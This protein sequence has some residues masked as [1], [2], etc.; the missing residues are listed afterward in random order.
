MKDNFWQ[1]NQ[2]KEKSWPTFDEAVMDFL[3]ALAAAIRCDEECI[4]Y[5]EIRAFGFWCR[6]S[7][8]IEMKE[9]MHYEAGKKYIGKGSVFHIAP[10]NVP[11]MFAYSLVLGLLAGNKN[12]VR[13]SSRCGEGDRH[14][15]RVIDE[16]L[17][18]EK[19][20]KMRER[21]I[22][23]QYERDDAITRRYINGSDACV[24]WGGDETVAK[25]HALIEKDGITEV[26]FPDRY[27]L[28]ILHAD[29][30]AKYSDEEMEHLAHRFYNDTYV[31]DQ[32]ACSSPRLVVWYTLGTTGCIQ[33]TKKRFWKALYK[34]SLAYP[35]EEDKVCAKFGLLAASTM[36]H[37]EISHV[38]RYDN[39]L[40]VAHLEKLPKQVD[41]LEGKFGFFYE[42]ETD[43]LKTVGDSVGEKLQTITV[44]EMKR[45]ALEH[46]TN[47][48]NAKNLARVVAIG[49]ALQMDMVWDNKNLIE[50]L[51]MVEK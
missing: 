29:E 27:G 17:A 13:I 39:R 40:Y 3:E 5:P 11:V 44:A 15:A 51:S 36:K 1:H 14:L 42:Y 4:G 2:N 35:L 25:M 19:H 50:E 26:S 48:K 38:T 6:R 32:N 30:L 16:V 37:E 9:R 7:N 18:Q 28:C 34:E 33:E 22:I 20:K 21:I 12:V 23:V 8:L 10:S 49:A 31:M 47:H 46:L 24:F 43:D 41:E 45:E